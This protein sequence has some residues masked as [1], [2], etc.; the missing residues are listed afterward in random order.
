MAFET[1]KFYFVSETDTYYYVSQQGFVLQA[2]SETE[3]QSC[4]IDWEECEVAFKRSD[5][6]LGA[7]REFSLPIKFALDG[8]KILR[9]VLYTQGFTG[10]VIFK[11]KK[12]NTTTL[13]YNDWYEGTVNLGGLTDEFTSVETNVEERGLIGKI[14]ALEDVEYEIPIEGPGVI[15]GRLDGVK[16]GARSSWVVGDS[17]ADDADF[18]PTEHDQIGLL[19][20]GH[21]FTTTR[22]SNDVQAG[23]FIIPRDAEYRSYG[24]VS[25]PSTTAFGTGRTSAKATA[26]WYQ[27]DF[28]GHID[29]LVNL[30]STASTGGQVYEMKIFAGI[31]TGAGVRD[32]NKTT[33]LAT[34]GGLQNAAWEEIS[35]DLSGTLSGIEANSTVTFYAEFH[36]LVGAIDAVRI[37]SYHYTNNS[38]ITIRY[39]AKVIPSDYVGF[40]WIDLMKRLVEKI[41]DGGSTC[42]SSFLSNPA[43]SLLSRSANFDNS[44]YNTIITSG[45]ALRGLPNPKIKISFK[46]AFS[47][48]FAEY[49]VGMEIKNNNVII[50]RLSHF[51][52]D[53]DLLHIDRI[54]NIT[55]KPRTEKVFNRLQI[56]YESHDTNNI[57][58]RNEFN[59]G[60]SFVVKDNTVV[61]RNEEVISPIRFDIYGIESVRAET[62]DEDRRDNRADNDTFGIEVQPTPV[63]GYYVPYRPQGA[64][65]TG[66][67]DPVGVYNV[68]L[69]PKRALFRHLPRIRSIVKKGILQYQ[70]IDKNPELISNLG[71]GTIVE[72]A[73]VN[74]EA[75]SV[76]GQPVLPLFT[77]YEVSFDCAPPYNLSE[78]LQLQTGGNIT[79]SFNGAIFKGIILDVGCRPGVND[80]YNFRLLLAADNDLSK[81]IR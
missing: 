73:D 29:M 31:V 80:K 27:I 19:P 59:T 70:S 33:L 54:N 20:A 3:V 4:V 25:P 11:I 43:A 65:I 78:I 68:A 7:F 13:Q 79:F 8:A 38:T 81:L 18:P 69:S 16:L 1:F 2:S 67:D 36:Q 63:N 44:P 39:L 75:D 46:S 49:C 66:V 42:I 22:M 9:H 35:V 62:F 24:S 77:N 40:R 34:V 12:L 14:K 64:V 21:T 50:E 56:G 5:F 71:S 30:E 6:Y 45:E 17:I 47:A 53:T 72:T 37:K 60:I 28:S 32:T 55:I 58:G 57:Q 52:P 26:E 41:S 76:N 15:H 61:V 10:V 74:L 51:L 48:L 23:S